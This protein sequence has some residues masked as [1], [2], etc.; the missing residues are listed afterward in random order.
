MKATVT[1]PTTTVD[2]TNVTLAQKYL[3]AI[4]KQPVRLQAKLVEVAEKRYGK[5]TVEAAQKRINFRQWMK[6]PLIDEETGEPMEHQSRE[7]FNQYVGGEAIEMY[8]P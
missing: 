2:Q 3:Q 7:Y 4:D 1:R 5:A 6:A 8:Q